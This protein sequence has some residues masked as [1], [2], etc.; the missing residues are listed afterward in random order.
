MN[1]WLKRT[2]AAGAIVLMVA[3]TWFNAQPVA[4]GLI[5]A[6]WDKLAHAGIFSTLC[7]ALVLAGWP[8]L[9]PAAV[10]VVPF[11]AFDELRQLY[12]PGRSADWGD[13]FTDLAAMA[14]VLACAAALRRRGVKPVA[15]G[16]RASPL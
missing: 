6:P 11:A 16:R 5:P 2:A 9:W 10:I 12:L 15:G 4:A 13:F 1:L 14:V 7:A 3:L 8:R